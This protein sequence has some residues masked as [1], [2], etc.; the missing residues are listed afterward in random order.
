LR[1]SAA[2]LEG[3]IY[4]ASGRLGVDTS[5][6]ERLVEQIGNALRAAPSETPKGSK[7]DVAAKLRAWC[8]DWD[9]SSMKRGEPPRDGL[10]CDDLLD[11]AD[12]LDR[13]ADAILEARK[14][15]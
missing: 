7:S 13:A 10:H 15:P 2:A 1:R 12:A 3:L 14:R 9:G 5:E 8:T 4:Q 11:A 6:E